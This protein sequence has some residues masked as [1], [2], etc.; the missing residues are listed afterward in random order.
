MKLSS[1]R[2]DS[3]ETSGR[4]DYGGHV[5]DTYDLGRSK[6]RLVEFDN[7]WSP[8]QSFQDTEIMGHRNELGGGARVVRVHAFEVLVVRQWCVRGGYSECRRNQVRDDGFHTTRWIRQLAVEV[9]RE[10][11]RRHPMDD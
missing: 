1:E 5:V 6:P 7:P 2:R 4:H 10:H 9:P 11:G 3:S 8:R